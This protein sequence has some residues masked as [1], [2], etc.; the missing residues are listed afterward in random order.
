MEKLIVT[1]NFF[2]S[3]D[4]FK[5]CLLL[6]RQNEYI[7][8]K[9]LQ[10]NLSYIV[11]A[12]ASIQVFMELPLPVLHTIFF[13]RNWL[14]FHV[15][16]VIRMDSIERRMNPVTFILKKKLAKSRIKP[17]KKIDWADGN[18]CNDYKCFPPPS[19]AP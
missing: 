16:I 2:S 14:L 11:A 1:S 5:S 15:T 6:M 18:T 7:W 3:H 17:A 10:N 13:P 12:R 19:Q 8:S 4:V 9:G